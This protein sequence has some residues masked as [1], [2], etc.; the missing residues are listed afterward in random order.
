MTAPPTE[1]LPRTNVSDALIDASS[2][3]STLHVTS[4]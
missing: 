2:S 4:P 3:L 1:L